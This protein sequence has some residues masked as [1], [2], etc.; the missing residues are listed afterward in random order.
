MAV[1]R[2]DNVGIVFA[3]LDAAIAFFSELGLELEGRTTI[4]GEW[5]DRVVGLTAQ[6]VDIAMM[7]TPDGGTK[8]ELMRYQRPAP[9]TPEP[10]DAPANT[11]GIRRL[12]FAVDDIHDTVERLRTHGAELV[13][14]I[15]PYEDIFLLCYLRGPEGVTIALAEQLR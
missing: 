1:L 13:G 5:S 15:V 10:A 4:E 2:M 12:M 6:R 3:D 9:I 11:L 8:L 14:D 7:R